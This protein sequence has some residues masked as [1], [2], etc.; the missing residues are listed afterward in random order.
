[1][2]D[3]LIH[4][5]PTSKKNKSNINCTREGGNELIGRVGIKF[6]TTQNSKLRLR[7]PPLPLLSNISKTFR[8]EGPGMSGSP[9]CELGSP[10][11]GIL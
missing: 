10:R 4:L 2:S 5:S 1:M 3:T 8:N 9:G 11:P 7:D 6:S